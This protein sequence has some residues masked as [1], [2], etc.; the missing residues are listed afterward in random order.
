MLRLTQSL[1]MAFDEI[2]LMVFL[3]SQAAI[4]LKTKAEHPGALMAERCL[5]VLPLIVMSK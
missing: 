1:P 2:S 3:T 5:M 4:F